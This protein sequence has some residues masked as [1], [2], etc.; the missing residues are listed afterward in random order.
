MCAVTRT[1][2]AGR[3]VPIRGG[4]GGHADLI[5]GAAQPVH[6]L[7]PLTRRESVRLFRG[8]G[9]ILMGGGVIPIGGSVIRIGDLTPGLLI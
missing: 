7:A 6:H 2:Y 4:T 3:L 8:R 9:E 5:F 1:I